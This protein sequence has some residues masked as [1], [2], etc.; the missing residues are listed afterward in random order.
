[1]PS[2]DFGPLPR[3]QPRPRRTRAAASTFS[4]SQP[5]PYR[6]PALSP[7][8]TP[9]TRAFEDV[10][11]SQPG[12]YPIVPAAS[13]M[14]PAPRFDLAVPSFSFAPDAP[15]DHAFDWSLPSLDFARTVV[16]RAAVFRSSSP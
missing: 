9:L 3:H 6:P 12:V 11:A 2:I 10:I 7:P 5:A 15:L 16:N 13:A 8:P 14:P 4:Q 1:M